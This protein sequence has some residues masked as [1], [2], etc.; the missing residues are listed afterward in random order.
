LTGL[1]SFVEDT[2][3]G[4]WT[5]AFGIILLDSAVLLRPSSFTF[6]FGRGLRVLVSP[7]R[8]PFL[9]RDRQPVITLIKHPFRAFFIA[10]PEAESGGRLT[11]RRELLARKRTAVACRQLC[12][13]A[14]ATLFLVCIAGPVLSHIAGIQ[15]AIIYVWLVVYLLALEGMLIV[16]F[17]RQSLNVG[18][19]K[20][21]ALTFELLVCPFLTANLIKK[22][23]VAQPTTVIARPVDELQET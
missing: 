1:I 9:I 13:P 16:I 11:S 21:A 5:I 15:R 3:Y 20:I 6:R 17:S 7:T 10:E 2:P 23:V 18:G 8:V 14:A 4:L 12:I 19:R 22:I